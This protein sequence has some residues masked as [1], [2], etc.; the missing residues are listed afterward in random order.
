MLLGELRAAGMQALLSKARHLLHQGPFVF[1]DAWA[2]ALTGPWEAVL[3]W[4]A[5]N[6][7][8]GRLPGSPSALSTSPGLGLHPHLQPI[9]SAEPSAHTPVFKSHPTGLAG[10]PFHARALTSDDPESLDSSPDLENSTID[11]TMPAKGGNVQD[12]ADAIHVDHRGMSSARFDAT[13]QPTNRVWQG[14][15]S[16][17]AEVDGFAEAPARRLGA[18][19]GPNTVA[20][21][22][23]G[24]SSLEV[25]V[26]A[27]LLG[28]GMHAEST[29][30][31]FQPPSGMRGRRM[32]PRSFRK[33]LFH[34]DLFNSEDSGPPSTSRQLSGAAVAPPGSAMTATIHFSLEGATWSSFSGMPSHQVCWHAEH[35]LLV[36]KILCI[37]LDKLVDKQW[38]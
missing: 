27:P 11:H 12:D 31:L 1:A 15:L 24:G 13:K 10:G 20:I 4:L 6:H 2:T 29:P 23:L 36:L 3:G 21:L 9:P 25:A 37:S 16:D 14:S 19:D 32:Q 5:V 22:D 28:P 17:E 18:V 8:L 30:R 38:A 7:S 35:R 34:M 33:I 26:Q